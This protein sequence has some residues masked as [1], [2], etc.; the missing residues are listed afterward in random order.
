MMSCATCHNP[1]LGWS[2]GLSKAVGHNHKQLGRKT[3]TILNLAWTDRMMWDGRAKN[4]EDQA[5]GPLANPDEMNM[6]MGQLPEKLASIPGYQKMFEKAFPGEKI[7]NELVAKAIAVYERGIVSEKSPFDKWIEGNEKAITDDAKSGFVL[8]NTKA[9]CAACHSGWRFTDDSFHDIGLN[10]NDL[11][12]G[13]FLKIQSQQHA[14]KTPGLRNI[15]SRA[16]YLHNGSEH[17]LEGVVE[18]YNRGGD[19]RR[20]SLSENIKP[21]EL[22][23]LEKKQI[24]EFMKSLSSKDKPVTFPEL[25]R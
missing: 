7:T 1:S 13:K 3:P 14:F 5:L 22:T 20:P 18:L 10:T 21:L 6:D 19:A 8:F 24:V 11:G 12:R 4:L 17:S 16:P 23:D 2:D 25:P 9:K 15:A